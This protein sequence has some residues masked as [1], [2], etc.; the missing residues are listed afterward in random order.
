MK[1]RGHKRK[2]RRSGR[3]IFVKKTCLIFPLQV[4][5]IILYFNDL[6]EI[7]QLPKLKSFGHKL[8]K[9]NIATFIFLKC[10]YF[11][12]EIYIFVS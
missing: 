5:N 9:I 8:V 2:R 3:G 1:G 7:Y 12:L 11:F 6:E 4:L 10:K